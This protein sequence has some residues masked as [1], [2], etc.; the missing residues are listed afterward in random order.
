MGRSSAWHLLEVLMAASPS[1][2]S[3]GAMCLRPACKSGPEVPAVG[4]RELS[5]RSAP[6]SWPCSWT[7][8]CNSPCHPRRH[9]KRVSW[10]SWDRCS[11]CW[12]TGRLRGPSS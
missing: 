10:P 9:C 1:T 2:P 11:W 6:S 5:P 12:R 3:G 8:R 7:T 4:G